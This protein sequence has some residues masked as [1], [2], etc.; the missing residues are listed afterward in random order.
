[1]TATD[2]PTGKQ[3]HPADAVTTVPRGSAY[4]SLSRQIKQ[5]G[6][7]DRRPGYYT[8][9]T[10]L[11]L[12]LVTVGVTAL[13]M[14]G[15]SWWQLL[16]AAYFA[17]LSTQLGFLGHD[18]GH[19]QIFRSARGNFCF[20]VVL[21]NLGVGFS[22]GW[23]VDKHNRHHAHPN[24][25]DKDPDIGAGALV[26]T[27]RQ[28]RASGRIGRV[29]Y[30]WQAW[31][32]FPL[33]MLEAINLRVSSVRY[34]LADRDRSR[35]REI[36]LI[37]LHVVAYL[38]VV[39]VVLPPGKA[40]A[41]VGV[42][43]A[44]FG[45]YLG[46]SFAPNHKGMPPLSDADNADYLRRQVLT[47]RNVRGHWL[48]DFALGGLNYQI[49]HHLFPSMPRGN[50]RRAQRLVKQFCADQQVS[51]LETGLISSYAQ[52]LRHLDTIGRAAAP[53]A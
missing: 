48:T 36:A 43:Q 24:D 35:I 31:T 12:L 52:A 18:A 41:F 23:W 47:S 32:F 38:A 15:D 5:A 8:A 9:Q 30:R 10:A 16:V 4:A 3:G 46:C 26:F 2:T 11:L 53:A 6:L 50:L 28:A 25:E 49:E 39:F 27:T 21:A 17:V 13:V 22:Y 19:R 45:L 7:L 33:L 20:G 1:M 51:Y 29:F 40:L 34:L 37:G 14:I 42:H 44:L